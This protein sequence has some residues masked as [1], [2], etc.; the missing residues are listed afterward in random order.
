MA[1]HQYL[2]LGQNDNELPVDIVLLSDDTIGLYSII[3]DGTI[4]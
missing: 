2:V 4:L 1:F 3:K